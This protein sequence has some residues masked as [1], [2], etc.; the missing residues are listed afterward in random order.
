MK[1]IF[2]ILSLI[3]VFAR[4]NVKASITIDL[5]GK[6]PLLQE[7]AIGTGQNIQPDGVFKG[8]WNK[9]GSYK[10]IDGN[11]ITTYWSCKGTKCQILS[12]ND[13][14]P[15]RYSIKSDY[16]PTITPPTPTTNSNK[17]ECYRKEL[18]NNKYDYKW[19]NKKIDEYEIISEIDDDK[20]CSNLNTCV[21]KDSDNSINPTYTCQNNISTSKIE[22]S[23]LCSVDKNNYYEFKCTESF[24]ANYEPQLENDSLKLTMDNNGLSIGFDYRIM[25]SVIKLCTG[26]F[27]DKL[28]NESYDKTKEIVSKFNSNTDSKYANYYNTIFEEIKSYPVR[29]NEKYNSYVED[30]TTSELNSANFDAEMIVSYRDS[31]TDKTINNS[32]IFD[33]KMISRNVEKQK[34]ENKCDN[35]E[36]IDDVVNTVNNEDECSKKCRFNSKD[37]P[38]EC[39]SNNCSMANHGSNCYSVSQICVDEHI[40]KCQ[41]SCNNTIVKAETTSHSNCTNNESLQVTLHDGNVVTPFSVKVVEKYELTAPQ[42]YLDASGKVVNRVYYNNIDEN[43]S[44]YVDG[45]HRFYLNNI[46]NGSDYTITTVIK[47]LGENKESSITNSNCPISINNSSGKYRIIN[48]KNPFVNNDRLNSLNNNWKNN[49]FDFTNITDSNKDNMYTFNLSKDNIKEI[50]SNNRN[51]NDIYLGTCKNIN[52]QNGIMYDICDIINSKNN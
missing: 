20:L 28:Y 19:S 32:Y 45:G 38:S 6:K 26:V 22:N 31:K 35:V 15:D 36:T 29:Y 2:I 51:D 39:I 16:H 8:G 18:G 42:T 52:N 25:L 1:K 21:L 44:K 49:L 40:K 47:N 33:K 14:Y 3:Y 37:I 24:V 4:I 43:N 30:V 9:Y 5:T 41:D 23:S 7:T 11:T 17:Y 48:T 13:S 34:I 46:Q 50:K 10:D 27:D 12:V